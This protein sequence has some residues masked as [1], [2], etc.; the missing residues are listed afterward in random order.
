MGKWRE[1]L[2]VS[3]LDLL[4]TFNSARPFAK[5]RLLFTH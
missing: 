3:I 5:L 1:M 4:V 2:L